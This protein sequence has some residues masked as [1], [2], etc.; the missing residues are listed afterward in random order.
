MVICV[1]RSPETY[2]K[3]RRDLIPQGDR[4]V[5]GAPHLHDRASGGLVPIKLRTLRMALYT[6]PI[7]TQG[8][9]MCANPA[10]QLRS[11]R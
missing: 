5:R 3:C 4:T 2:V 7:G 1:A 6:S 11:Y 9:Q 8:Y 10:S